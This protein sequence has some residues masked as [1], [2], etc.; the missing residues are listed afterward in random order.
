MSHVVLL[1]GA[2]WFD[3]NPFAYNQAIV[4]AK[5]PYEL[6][7]RNYVYWG[8][9]FREH[10]KDG[11]SKI[12]EDLGEAYEP[13]G[14]KRLCDELNDQIK[15]ESPVYLYLINQWFF[16][17]PLTIAQVK[18]A[19]YTFEELP[20]L[21]DDGRPACAHIPHYYFL[22]EKPVAD[23]QTCRSPQ[24]SCK[25]RFSCNFW[26]QVTRFYPVPHVRIRQVLYNLV[27]G[28]D[29]IGKPNKPFD[30]TGAALYPIR[31]EQ[32]EF[33]EF[34]PK[35]SPK[36]QFFERQLSKIPLV[37]RDVAR[38]R[39]EYLVASKCLKDLRVLPGLRLEALKGD[40]KGQHSIRINKKWRICFVW[41]EGTASEIELCDYH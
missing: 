2:Q 8:K 32:T 6:F 25:L 40:R 37:L 14:G 7:S 35:S 9:F 10:F 3:K 34:F 31:V 18:G 36:Q 23:C 28:D 16:D 30:P 20:P 22:Y 4:N 27:Y 24:Q 1:W 29:T 26:F 33:V 11:T 12:L 5:G 38:H 21:D 13:R 17:Q 41:W 39:L 19:F 15:K